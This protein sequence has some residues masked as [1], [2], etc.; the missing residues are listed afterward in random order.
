[1]QNIFEFGVQ[2]SSS[3]KKKEDL[4]HHVYTVPKIKKPLNKIK[5]VFIIRFVNC[6]YWY[7][8]SD[9]WFTS[10]VQ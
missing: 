5:Y 7:V 4:F 8:I 3:Y 10:H 9:I 2:F 1:M 6:M